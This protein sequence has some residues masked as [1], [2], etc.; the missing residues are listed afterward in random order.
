MEDIDEEEL[1]V[2]IKDEEEAQIK[3]L[4]SVPFSHKDLFCV[5]IIMQVKFSL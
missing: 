4:H 1:D 3:W 2:L 5:I